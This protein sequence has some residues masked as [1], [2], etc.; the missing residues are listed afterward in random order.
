MKKCVK[1]FKCFYEK[2]YRYYSGVRPAIYDPKHLKELYIPLN[3]IL[4]YEP[5]TVH[6]IDWEKCSYDP[7][8]FFSSEKL[9]PKSNVDSLDDCVIEKSA[10]LI[11]LRSAF[12]Y[13]GVYVK[14]VVAVEPEV[15]F[16]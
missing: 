8:G 12:N 11:H 3:Q 4:V 10:V 13:D 16:E 6:Y 9:T 1:K 5:M 2:D 14:R 7:G 15:D